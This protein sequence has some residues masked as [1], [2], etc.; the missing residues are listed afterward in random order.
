MYQVMFPSTV[1]SFEKN[2]NFYD[3]SGTMY[4]KEKIEMFCL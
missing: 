3:I 1:Y 4:A 2:M